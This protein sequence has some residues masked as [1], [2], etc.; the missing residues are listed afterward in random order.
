[1]ELGAL[2]DLT[3]WPWRRCKNIQNPKR[4]KFF[5]HKYKNPNEKNISTF[6]LVAAVHFPEKTSVFNK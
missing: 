2:L 1:M 3:P 6:H 4:I 5:V